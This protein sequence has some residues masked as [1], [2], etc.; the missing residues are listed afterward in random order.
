MI[1]ATAPDCNGRE[2]HDPAHPSPEPL[3]PDECPSCGEVGS[4]RRWGHYLRHLV[5]VTGCVHGRDGLKTHETVVRVQRVRCSKCGRTHALLWCGIVPYSPFSARTLMLLC[6]LLRT[7]P[8]ASEAGV[9]LHAALVTCRR[10]WSDAARLAEALRCAI[11]DLP[12]ALTDASADAASVAALCARF[13]AVHG[14]TPFSRVPL[15]GQG[16]PTQHGAPAASRLP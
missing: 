1:V 6:V 7:L 14:T 9:A 3:V 5:Y 12:E 16:P 2:R 13:A 8:R 11:D 10:A 15:P 4:L